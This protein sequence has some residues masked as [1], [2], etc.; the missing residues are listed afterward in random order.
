MSGKKKSK[1]KTLASKI[2]RQS[3][4]EPSGKWWAAL[5]IAASLAIAYS[6]SMNGP[7]IFDDDVNIIENDSIR[8]L[9]PWHSLFA[10]MESGLAGRP[11][12][13]FSLALNYAISGS[14]VWS[15]H[16]LN[17][18]IHILAALT[19]FGIVRRT[20]TSERLRDRYGSAATGL[21]LI[22][23]LLW[24][25]HPLQT[26]AV[27][28]IIQR[29]ESLMGLFFLLTLYGS[30]RG[31]QSANGRRWHTLALIACLLG[32]GT[33]EVIAAAPFVVLIYDVLI[34][35]RRPFD[36]LKQ[37]PYLYGGF[38]GCLITLGV[39][40][41]TAGRVS[42]GNE[43]PG[44]TPWQYALTQTQVILYYIRLAFWPSPLCLDYGWR[45]ATFT[46]AL[47]SVIVLAGLVGVTSWATWKR[48]L[49]AFPAIC[50]F[51][52]I[53]PSS[54]LIPIRDLA[55][56]HR[57]YLSLAGIV[58]LVTVGAYELIRF[59]HIRSQSSEIEVRRM[60]IAG[61][62]AAIIIALL[63]G[64]LTYQRNR[65]Y[66]SE[67]SIWNDTLDKQPG[68]PRANNNL[69]SILLKQ[70]YPKKA[71]PYLIEAIRLKPDYANAHH[72]FGTALTQL[73]QAKAAVP[74]FEKALEIDPDYVNA[75]YN[76]GCALLVIDE[77]SKAIQQFEIVKKAKLKD[78]NIQTADSLNQIDPKLKSDL[79]DIYGNLANA[80][81]KAGEPQRA[82]ENFDIVL[83]LA[84]NNAVAHNNM[85][86]ILAQSGQTETA[87]AHFRKA[88][89][90]QPNY[91]DAHRNLGRSLD[92]LHRSA[93][94]LDHFREALRLDPQDA[95]ALRNV[96]RLEQMLKQ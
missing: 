2:T 35:D 80:L 4:H 94:A 47:P 52:A 5:L 45:I 10:P 68:N 18:L 23:A 13:N 51:L 24:G 1:T 84:P 75:R 37:P 57:M 16:A 42:A 79:A 36:A 15:Y 21:A 74:H 92:T 73:G 61:N 12:V 67:L 32:V 69:A 20:L 72:N 91:A 87:L 89:W 46:Q 14:E 11:V 9:W 6:N 66:R 49:L 44:F 82:V 54:S 95:V 39:L 96:E 31:W 77:P 62:T 85:G 63:F 71:L 86:T 55:F 65:D 33:K 48:Y 90:I 50:F 41:A 78:K 25:L 88:V 22:V 93:E 58:V 26:Q 3:S 29:C 53:A 56:E 38:L 30:I 17:L 70:K 76:L 34:N 64:L 8:S 60:I 59:S 19:L 27:T 83:Q 28:Y 43:A 40:I 7:F 81:Y